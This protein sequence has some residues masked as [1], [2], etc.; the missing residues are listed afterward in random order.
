MSCPWAKIET[1]QPPKLKEIM[2]E[3]AAKEI[4]KKKEKNLESK[5]ENSVNAANCTEDCLVSANDSQMEFEDD[6]S[7][8]LVEDNINNCIEEDLLEINNINNWNTY[9][10]L[11]DILASKPQCND[12]IVSL[13]KEAKLYDCYGKRFDHIFTNPNSRVLLANMIESQLILRIN[14]VINIGKQ[15]VILQADP[16]FSFESNLWKECVIKVFQPCSEPYDKDD[17]QF[18]KN[19]YKYYLYILRRYCLHRPSKHIK[20]DPRIVSSENKLAKLEYINLRK[21]YKAKV[22]CPKVV[23]LKYHIMV[24]SF[25]GEK[26]IPAP[27]L[28]NATMTLDDYVI[29]YEQ[30]IRGMKL[31][32]NEAQVIHADLSENKILWHKGQCYFIDLIKAVGRRHDYAMYFL[33]KDC[34]TI[35]KFFMKKGVQKVFS[36]EELFEYITGF[37]WEE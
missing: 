8:R 28:K 29:A 17:W 1:P 31:M 3:E 10:S 22:P 27:T 14:E 30:V 36:P 23:I 13:K 26:G 7:S 2:S 33:H 21:L 15:T 37:E 9:D 18:Y 19:P 32:F 12:V 4:Q 24:M 16:N 11:D 34:S 20:F 5:N 6:V 25:I 35:T